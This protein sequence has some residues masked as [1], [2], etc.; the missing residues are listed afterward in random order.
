MKQLI[1]TLILVTLSAPICFGEWSKV[2]VVVD[3]SFTHYVD[4]DSIIVP[5]SLGM[6]REDDGDVHY[7]YLLD[8]VERG[9]TGEISAKV[10]NQGDCGVFRKKILTTSYFSQPMGEGTMVVGSAEPDEGWTY[11]TPDSVGEFI[12]KR[13]CQIVETKKNQDEMVQ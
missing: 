13:V 3:D 8:Y 2:M 1:L 5:T 7:W 11:P 12:L 10:Y 6:A 9:E 4:F